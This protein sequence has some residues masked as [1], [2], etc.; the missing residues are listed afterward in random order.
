LQVLPLVLP[1]VRQLAFHLPLAL[2]L[3]LPLVLAELLVQFQPIV[4][5]VPCRPLLQYLFHYH[6]PMLLWLR[7]LLVQ[8]L[9][10]RHLG[11]QD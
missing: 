9:M 8:P 5:N 3:L 6:C 1:L 11:W 10:W 2:H 7:L 4:V